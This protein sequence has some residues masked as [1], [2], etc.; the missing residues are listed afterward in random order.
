MKRLLV[1]TLTT[2]ALATSAGS[3]ADPSPNELRHPQRSAEFAR[4]RDYLLPS[5]SEQ[6]YRKIA[7]RASVL[8]GVV[9]AQNKDKPLMLVLMNGHPLSC[10]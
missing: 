2:A 10:T 6:S 9:D 5:A 4:W 8:Q 1:V 3:A 7:W